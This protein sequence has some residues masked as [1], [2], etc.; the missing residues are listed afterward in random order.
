MTFVILP[1]GEGI[2]LV[3]A[4]ILPIIIL[5]YCP[6]ISLTYPLLLKG[7]VPVLSLFFYP[8]KITVRL[9]SSPGFVLFSSFFLHPF[10]VVKGEEEDQVSKLS[11]P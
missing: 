7:P 6:W 3:W 11:F 5:L 9:F 8:A 1:P 4:V 10:L 2:P